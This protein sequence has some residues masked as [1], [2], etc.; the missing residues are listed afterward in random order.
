[1]VTRNKES[2]P[3]QPKILDL[4]AGDPKSA[5]PDGAISAMINL[6]RSMIEH[7]KATLKKQEEKDDSRLKSLRH[8]PN[9]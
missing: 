8:S 3:K 5:V 6:S 9:I 1:M 7:Q 4:T 2:Q